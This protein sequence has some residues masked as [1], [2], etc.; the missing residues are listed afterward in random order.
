MMTNTTHRRYNQDSHSLI[1]ALHDR[2]I[3]AI[4]IYFVVKLVLNRLYITY[5]AYS[6]T[7]QNNLNSFEFHML[8]I[9]PNKEAKKK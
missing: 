1:L 8:R 2:Y 5:D 4:V 7:S 6:S 9:T 3:T